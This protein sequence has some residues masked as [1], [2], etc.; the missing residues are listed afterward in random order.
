MDRL[1]QD[2]R[3]AIRALRR[4]PTPAAATVLILGLAIGMAVAMATLVHTVLIRRLPVQ[5][6]DRVVVLWTYRV[7]SVES[8]AWAFDLPEIRRS[9]RTM[10]D[11]A[12]VEHHGTFP[13]P[14]LDG[15]RT[16]MVPLSWV[17][18]NYFDVLGARPS[19]GRLFRPED[20]LPG[21]APVMVLS[22]R[23]WRAEFGADPSVV[24]RHLVEPFSHRAV[25]IIGVAPPGLDYPIGAAAWRTMDSAQ[26]SGGSVILGVGRLASG[27]TLNAARAEFFS[28]VNRLEPASR[29]TGARAETFMTAV[30]GEVRP[31]LVVLAAAVALLL[32][33]AC[34]NVGTLFLVRAATR[35]RELEVRRALGATSWDIAQQLGVESGVLGILGAVGGVIGGVV[36]L[37]GL[38]AAAPPRLPRL[39]TVRLD[40]ASVAVAVGL[41]GVAVLCFGLLPSLTIVGLHPRA[42]LRLDARAGSETRRRRR[43][44]QG[45][46]GS[47]VALALVLLA[48]AGLLTRSFLRLEGLQLGFATQHLS[49]VS[50]A[51]DATRY[52]S[53]AKQIQL[54]QQLE[55]RMRAIPGVSA[56]TPLLMAPFLGANVWHPPFEAEGE[57]VT[58]RDANPNLPMEVAGSQYFGAFG[59]PIVR[60]RG[61]LDTD[62]EGGA[63]VVV[64]SESVARRFWPG[65][66]PIGKRMRLAPEPLTPDSE[67]ATIPD[68]AWR[69]V[70]GVVPDTRF[71]AL[72]E[73]TP[74]VYLPWRQVALSWFQG[75]F[76]VRA[77]VDAARLAGE[78]ERAVTGVDPTLAVYQARSADDLLG[79]SLAEPRLS[80]LLLSAL[81]AVALLLAAVGLYGVMTSAVRE[82]TREI[83]IRAALGATPA[84]IRG[85]ILRRSLII[86]C[87]GAGAGLLAA[88]AITRALRSLLFEVTPF[89][90]LTLVSACAVLIAVALVAT[91]LPARRATAIDPARALRA[92]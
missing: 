27:A 49:I 77:Q 80:A 71:R 18:A 43:V 16:W 25:S 79:S 45:L 57:P 2:L 75:I 39:D 33:I 72:R 62:R 11:I 47:Q 26:K 14:Y 76:A 69:S 68:L 92:E 54:G 59:I 31:M 12:G 87:A 8:S 30:V 88:I 38:V 85:S 20:D 70:V 90:P 21:A 50:I 58:G 28:I 3:I 40:S 34:V 63:P 81:S 19:L 64:V 83:G 82:E 29:L 22:N 53:T 44:R 15:D 66:D 17:S 4:S 51:F 9:V 61:F 24:G 46:V 74:M 67:I 7:P 13:M 52:D 42:S 89:D 73:T 65:Q 5:D 35:A 37:H 41:A 48:G 56:V 32:L 60:G 6:P 1:A 55:Q 84:V 23:S 78:V 10:R 86:V 36:I 91:Y